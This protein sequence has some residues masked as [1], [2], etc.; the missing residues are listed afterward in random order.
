MWFSD[1]EHDYRRPKAIELVRFDKF[2]LWVI[3]QVI[4]NLEWLY[5]LLKHLMRKC[6][7]IVMETEGC[8]W[9]G[10]ATSI[11][12]FKRDNYFRTYDDVGDTD[13]E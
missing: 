5:K 13:K 10:H 12:I 3:K 4:Q 11:R 7:F 1:Y 6:Q 8:M 2:K 9:H